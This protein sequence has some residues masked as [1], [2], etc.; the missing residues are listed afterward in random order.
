MGNSV[1]VVGEPELVKV[2]VHTEDPSKVLSYASRM[3][4]LTKTKVDD[5]SQQHRLILDESSHEPAPEKKQAPQAR[6]NGV[7]VVT[8]VAGQGLVDIFRGLG[9]DEVAKK[10]LDALGPKSFELVT[11][12]RGE[13]AT[14]SEVERLTKALRDGFPGLEIELQT[15]GQQHYPFILSVE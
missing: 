4:T 10:A 6:G 3:G 2:H 8:V 1:L 7:G 15:G 14:D 9:V 11:V 5:M 13:Q 12:Y